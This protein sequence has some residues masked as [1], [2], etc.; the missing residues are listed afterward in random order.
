MS[1]APRRMV[2]WKSITAAALVILLASGVLISPAADHRD[3]P[4]FANTVAGVS[5]NDINDLY[6]FQSPVDAANTVMVMTWSPFTGALLPTTFDQR[7]FFDLRVDNNGDAQEDLIFRVT[8]GA[9]DANGI[10]QV[11][12]RGLPAVQFPNGGI[13]AK[14]LTGQNL[15][16]AG[17]GM[18]RAA[19][20]DDPFFFDAPAVG[21]F[22]RDGNLAANPVPRATPKNF[23]KDANILGFV[24]EIPTATLL[25][26]PNNPLLGA[27]L[28][29]ELDGVVIDRAGRPAI[30]TALVPPVPRND[31][32]RG[33]RRNAFNAG[34]PQNDRRDFRDDMLFVLSNTNPNSIYKRT[35]ADAA[36]LADFL[37][38]D[39][40]TYDTSKPAAY[41]NGRSLRDDVIDISL[42][43]LSNGGITSDGVPDDNTTI[44]DG[45]QG[46]VAA[47]PYL[48]PPNNPPGF[49]NP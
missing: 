45:Q 11:T 41:P 6:L 27:F 13:L 10:Q 46:S 43:L 29:T 49:P 40:L 8:F 42:N 19:V 20:F 30:N 5:D 15:P 47:F 18:F 39:L 16:I 48:G 23:F 17:G 21:N 4:I 14:G 24:I 22:L 2:P 31:P 12:L 25:S 9:P 44:T 35:A 33:D 34:L 1:L 32:T 28:R 26:A 36:A 7:V 37:L 38:P 3:G